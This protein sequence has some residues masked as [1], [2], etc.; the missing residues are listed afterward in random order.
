MVL[1][2][3]GRECKAD[4]LC[5]HRP[6]YRFRLLILM[7]A[8]PLGFISNNDNHSLDQESTIASKN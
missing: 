5:A 7:C 6:I 2:G 1:G 8:A 3:N 4:K